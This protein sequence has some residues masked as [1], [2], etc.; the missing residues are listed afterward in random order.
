MSRPVSPTL[1]AAILLTLSLLAFACDD[2]GEGEEKDLDSQSDVA[3]D[4]AA[5]LTDAPDTTDAVDTNPG[6]LP[7]TAELL[8]TAELFDTAQLTDIEVPA[9]RFHAEVLLGEGGFFGISGLQLGPVPGLGDVFAIGAHYAPIA[10][11]ADAGRV[12][13]FGMGSWPLQVEEAVAVLEPP[14]GAAQGG[15]GF[16]FG[17]ACD[18]DKDGFPDLPVGNHLYGP[19]AALSA[20]GRVVVFMGGA[21]GFDVQRTKFLRLDDTLRTRSDSMGQTVLCADLDGDGWGDVLAGGQNAGA[22]DTGLVAIWHGSDAGLAEF[23]DQLLT[24]P[25]L[26]NRQYLGAESLWADLNGDGAEDLALGAWGLIKGTD[27]AGVHTG[28]ILVFM[29]GD[30]WSAGPSLILTPPEDFPTQMGGMFT[31]AGDF[32]VAGAG[33]F[34]P[35][36]G[37]GALGSCCRVDQP[38]DAGL[39]C[40]DDFEFPICTHACGPT[41]ICTADE[42]CISVDLTTETRDMCLVICGPGYPE[43]PA[44]MDCISAGTDLSVCTPGMAP[45]AV[46][47]WPIGSD[48]ELAQS[49]SRLDAPAGMAGMGFGDSLAW[50]PDYYADGEG[51]LLVGMR[52]ADLGGAV[53]VFPVTPDGTAFSTDPPELLR[54]PTMS[55]DWDSFGGNITALGDVDGDGLDDFF[56]AIEGH[57]EGD[58][59]GDGV[60]TGGVVFYH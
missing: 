20:S 50:T 45:G 15:F 2:P 41:E 14:D 25:L 56:I 29:G 42:A 51:A 4:V 57:V 47:V 58:P 13:L 44:T 40:D 19:S 52:Y 22:N 32:L 28:G 39:V 59:F 10:S 30:D 5:E 3:A 1:I 53:A 37:T 18:V 54:S 36:Q 35:C 31:L 12:Y 46:Y 6:E 33:N 21:D 26:A 24:T 60:Q 23:P 38:C 16:D 9:T 55:P 8:D 49:P 43:C 7:D 48:A 34:S 17:P 11:G 27:T